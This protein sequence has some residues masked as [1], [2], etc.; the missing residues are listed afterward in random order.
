MSNY[1]IVN[2]FPSFPHP[3]FQTP[4]PKQALTQ[5]ILSLTLP[6]LVSLSV[7]PLMSAVDTIYV[8]RL[9]EDL[10]GGEVRMM[11]V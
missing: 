10:G 6:A 7:D 3:P 1:S 9:G 8:G 4:L 2:T 11:N 5:Q